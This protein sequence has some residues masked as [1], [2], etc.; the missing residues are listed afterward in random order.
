ARDRSLEAARVAEPL[1]IGQRSRNRTQTV[2]ALDA[3]MRVAPEPPR[4]LA[5]ARR[6]EHALFRGGPQACEEARQIP[7]RADEAGRRGERMRRVVA[8][9]DDTA[10]QRQVGAV[11]AR[12]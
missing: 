3:R 4:H 10:A 11:A 12:E 8:W 5:P 9:D 7:A 6:R 2:P 1:P